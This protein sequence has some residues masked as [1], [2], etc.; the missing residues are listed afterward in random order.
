MPLGPGATLGPYEVLAPLGAGGMGEV[1]RARDLRLGRDVAIKLL[2]GDVGGD[3]ERLSRFRRE[4]H[5]LASLNHPGMGGFAPCGPC[6]R[7]EPWPAARA[8]D[9]RLE[10]PAPPGHE[11]R[12]GR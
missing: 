3:A 1:C 10:R 5:V 4:V 6:P 11:H 9:R 7:G 2:P 8:G 12:F